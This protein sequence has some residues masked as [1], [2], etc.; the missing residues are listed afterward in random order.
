MVKGCLHC[1][2]SPGSQNDDCGDHVRVRV[3]CVWCIPKIC[4]NMFSKPFL[5]YVVFTNLALI[6][7]KLQHK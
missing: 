6:R 5:E 2:D 7:V 3:V 1:A 4:L